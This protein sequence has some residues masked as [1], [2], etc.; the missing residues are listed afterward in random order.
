MSETVLVEDAGGVRTLTL[1]RPARRNALTPEMQ[2]T[3]TA[4][5]REAGEDPGCRVVVLSGGG[6]ETFCAGL[7]LK[8]MVAMPASDAAAAAAEHTAYAERVARMLRTLY[9]CPKPTIAAVHGAAIG[10]GAGLA[11]ICDFTL[12][13][14]A[15]WFA[16]TEVK[17]G[18]VPAIVSA[19]LVLQVGEK[20]ARDLLLTGREINAEEAYR[21]GLV[22]EL[23]PQ[24][25]LM[26]RAHALA[27]ALVRN[28]PESLRATKALLA[29]QNKAWLDAAVAEAMLVNA[30]AR[31]SS[32]F[33]E[34]VNAF[35]EK[36]T[37]VWGKKK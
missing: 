34:G 13:A 16:F 25:A 24:G 29:A 32:D 14:P 2:D 22:N 10:G 15:A 23:P 12:A 7:D 33:R 3:L 20:R 5:L 8:A 26:E 4:R 18:F 27:T 1:H 30:A 35:L 21:M 28:S 11:T 36:R 17:I 9:E 31:E 19:Y 37:P 6:G